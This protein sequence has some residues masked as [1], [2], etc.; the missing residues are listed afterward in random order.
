MAGD[1]PTKDGTISLGLFDSTAP[2]ANAGSSATKF[3]AKVDEERQEE[4][5]K[6]TAV[7]EEDED[8]DDLFEDMA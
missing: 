5:K 1:A 4:T 2:N 8:E 6:T 3:V 7:E